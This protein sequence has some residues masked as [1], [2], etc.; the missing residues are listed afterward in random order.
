MV[1]LKLP[2]MA[3][4][5]Y[6]T[7]VRKTP[8]L[9]EA[10]KDEKL[11]DVLEQA[12]SYMENR[13]KDETAT[14]RYLAGMFSYFQQCVEAAVPAEL[15]AFESILFGHIIY[16]RMTTDFVITWNEPRK[17]GDR[18][19]WDISVNARDFGATPSHI[20]GLTWQNLNEDIHT[21]IQQLRKNSENT[22]YEVSY[23]S[24]EEAMFWL[25]FAARK[26][27]AVGC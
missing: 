2:D 17:V 18:F 25:E 21:H 26:Q 16:R 10:C 8:F 3:W 24:R 20:L 22:F 13:N 7:V 4:T 19:I 9:H 11:T 12:M 14:S 15:S 6:N 1:K 5:R 27:A 23:P